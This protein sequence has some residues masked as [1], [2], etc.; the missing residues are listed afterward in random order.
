MPGPDLMKED[1]A[2]REKELA[3]YERF[4]KLAC[5]RFQLDILNTTVGPLLNPDPQVDPAD[6]SR[7]G[8]AIA[9][10]RHWEQA[11]EGLQRLAATCERLDLR[12]ALEIHGGYLHDLPEPTLRL[13]EA[14]GSERIGVNLDYGNI[15]Y[16]PQPPSLAA[17]VGLL[18]NHLLVVH[19]KNSIGFGPYRKNISLEQGEIN[20]REFLTLLKACGFAGYLCP[21]APRQGDR[22]A[23]AL[24]DLV[25]LKGLLAELA[26]QEEADQAAQVNV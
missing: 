5:E 18:K 21:E 22:E 26:A 13:L 17:S 10:P 1:A 12:L 24:P 6:N 7:M 14:V 4:L 15:V 20:N 25:Y 11:V 9:S 23:F 8:S 3:G 16:F 19:L 2:L